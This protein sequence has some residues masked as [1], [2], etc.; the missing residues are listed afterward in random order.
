MN[1]KYRFAEIDDVDQLVQL[2]TLM[3]LE[4]NA[5]KP[6]EYLQSRWIFRTKICSF[7][8]QSSI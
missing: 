1:I 4:A 2:R 6:E 7:G 3:Q 5:Y 8:N